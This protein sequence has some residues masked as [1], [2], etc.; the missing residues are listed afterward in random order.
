MLVGDKWTQ[1]P[2]RAQ[3]W[4]SILLVGIRGPTGNVIVSN[5]LNLEDSEG[6]SL[7]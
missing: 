3:G 1:A 2:P 5:Y 4:I 6:L 7:I